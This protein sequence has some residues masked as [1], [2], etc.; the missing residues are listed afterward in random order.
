MSRHNPLAK[1]GV[2]LR[3]ATDADWPVIRKWLAQADVIRWWGP[4]ATTEAEVM[5]ALATPQAVCR[6][7]EVETAPGAVEDVGYAHALETGLAGDSRTEGL[8]PGTWRLDLFVA[9]TEFRGRG[10][11]GEAL[12][13]MREEVFATT[14][15]LAVVAFVAIGNEKAV[16][17]YEN[18]GFKWQSVSR[19]PWHQAEWLMVHAHPA[20]GGIGVEATAKHPVPGRTNRLL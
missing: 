15:A 2:R 16:R 3:E 14:L 13:L 7:I 1:P 5:L 18:A 9:A 20:A 6:I 4:K 10:V 11:G 8:E 17:A 12:R 19:A